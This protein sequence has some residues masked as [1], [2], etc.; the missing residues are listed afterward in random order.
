MPNLYLRQVCGERGMRNPAFVSSSIAH[1]YARIRRDLVTSGRWARLWQSGGSSAVSLLPV[2]ALLARGYGSK[3]AA[4]R[5]DRLATISGLSRREV[6]T[7]FE[8]LVDEGVVR[9]LRS[10]FPSTK[11]FSLEDLLV[12]DS[13]PQRFTITGALFDK[14]IWSRLDPE[15]KACLIAVL[16]LARNESR[17]I[18]VDDE[19]FPSTDETEWREQMERQR[20]SNAP[21]F[22]EWYPSCTGATSLRKLAGFSGLGDD[23]A[24]VLESLEDRNRSLIHTR[25]VGSEVWIHLPAWTWSPADLDL[26]SPDKYAAL[27]KM[28]EAKA[29]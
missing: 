4:V 21:A 20:P 7:G 17:F 3:G 27:N 12:S 9:D 24:G 11:R 15:E 6:T 19:P 23:V 5:I 22:R 25:T 10:R 16:A 28:P 29:K 13:G 14:G 18:S 1:Q 26:H 8:L 2:L